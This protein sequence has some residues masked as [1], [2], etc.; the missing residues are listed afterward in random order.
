M[1]NFR[2]EIWSFLRARLEGTDITRMKEG[3]NSIKLNIP[4][5]KQNCVLV[6][7]PITDDEAEGGI[8]HRDDSKVIHLREDLWRSQRAKVE[9]RLNSLL[10]IS[11]RIYGRETVLQSITNDDL[12]SF[13]VTNHLNVPIRAKYKYGLFYNDRLAAVMSFSKGRAMVR[14]GDAYNSFELLRFCSELNCTVVGGFTKL[15]NHFIQTVR[16]D[17]IMTYVDKDW[18]DGSNYEKAGF[19]LE[20]ELEPMMFL[21]DPETGERLYPHRIVKSGR[22]SDQAN[23]SSGKK[24]NASLSSMAKVYNSGSYKFVLLLKER[25]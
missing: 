14:H 20:K 16:P 1:D 9:S 15:L 6:F 23:L 8:A 21:I 12:I 7:H 13:L 24:D 19:V 3:I 17:D 4:T 22:E 5:L 11:S 18:S 2:D 10:G 25:T